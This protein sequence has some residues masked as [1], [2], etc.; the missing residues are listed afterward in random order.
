MPT[1]MTE[2][3]YYPLYER[4][5]EILKNVIAVFESC[6][7]SIRSDKHK[8]SSND[9]LSVLRGPLAQKGFRVETGKGMNQKVSVPVL[10]GRNGKPEKSFDADAYHEDGKIVLEVEAGRGVTNFQF[11]KDLFQ[12]CVMQDVDYL[13]IAVRKT[14][15]GKKDFEIAASFLDSLYANQRLKLPLRGILIL[16]Y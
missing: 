15:L 8:L 7:D 12:A 9:A 3:Q 16:G 6:Y 1:T 14:Y 11:L 5:N 2:W 13:V 4:P 10:F